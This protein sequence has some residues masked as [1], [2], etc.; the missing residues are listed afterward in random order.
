MTVFN[1]AWNR[2]RELVT[3][4]IH[5]RFDLYSATAALSQFIQNKEFPPQ[6]ARWFTGPDFEQSDKAKADVL[7][8]VK[9]TYDGILSLL[10][11]GTSYYDDPNQKATNYGYSPGPNDETLAVGPKFWTGGL[12]V[13]LDLERYG[14]IIHELSHVAF[15]SDVTDKGGYFNNPA[16]LQNETNLVL[17]YE[18]AAN[19]QL[20]VEQPDTETLLE[21]ADAYAGYLTQYYYRWGPLR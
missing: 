10:D 14:T 4:V 1:V 17:W 19:T 8:A 6:V 3:Q 13:P 11:G 21:T 2:A 9:S 15:L 20:S 18:D 5:V 7:K 12:N 16:A